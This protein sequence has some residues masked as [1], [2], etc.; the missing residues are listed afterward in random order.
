MRGDSETQLGLFP[1]VSEET[2][3]GGVVVHTVD[4]ALCIAAIR[5]RGRS[6]WALPKGHLNAGET[7]LAAAIREVREE[8]GLEVALGRG[9]GHIHYEYPF[10]GRRISKHVHFFLFRWKAG[11]IDAL[12][13]EMRIEVSEARWLPLELARRRLSYAGEREV[14]NR[15]ARLIPGLTQRSKG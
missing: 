12:A 2:S 14:L 8:T 10:R 13:P 4:G 11:E 7:P 9:L 15:A 1:A 6:L 3:A 5:P